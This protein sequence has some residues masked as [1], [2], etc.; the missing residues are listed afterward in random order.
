MAVRI[1]PL[2]TAPHP[3]WLA[4]RRALWPECPDAEHER[5]MAA[6]VADPDTF[7][8]FIAWSGRDDPIGFAEAAIRRDAVNGATLSPVPFLEGLYV[9]PA[10]RRR[11]VARALVAAVIGWARAAGYAELASD[12]R[13]GNEVSHA[14]HRALGFQE[15]ERVVCFRRPLP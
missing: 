3:G 7:V 12:A 6:Q 9:V 4:L 8:Q 10:A 14:L 5:D 13:L 15:T 11:G 2:T 1:E